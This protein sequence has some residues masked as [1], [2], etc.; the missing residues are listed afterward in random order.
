MI[1]VPAED[2]QFLKEQRAKD[3]TKNS[4]LQ[5]GPADVIATQT[6]RRREERKERTTEGLVQRLEAENL[7]SS[8]VNI[9]DISI[10]EVNELSAT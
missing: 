7:Q 10:S 9:N 5:I 3:G 6:A 1:Q 2:R 8:E 4:G